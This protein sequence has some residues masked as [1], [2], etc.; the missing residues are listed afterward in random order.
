MYREAQG[1]SG[2]SIFDRIKHANALLSSAMAGNATGLHQLLYEA[3]EPRKGAPGDV[4]KPTDGKYS[5]E[6][7]RDLAKSALKKYV[8]AKG[9]L[10]SQFAQYAA[11][12]GTVVIPEPKVIEAAQAFPSAPA[13]PPP[14]ADD[15]RPVEA[16]QAMQ[17]IVINLPE[18]QVPTATFLPPSSG[19]GAP[20]AVD[21]GS[22]GEDTEPVVGGEVGPS[23]SFPTI[24][25]VIGI[26][27]LAF[28]FLRKKK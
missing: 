6:A 12:L 8:K 3:F 24:P 19:G 17:P 28:L 22:G 15:V 27:A 2:T 1:L 21:D 10:P 11:R 9:G 18:Q 7:V 4:R 26:G 16:T 14:P 13:S 20:Y 23:S 25:L 5:P